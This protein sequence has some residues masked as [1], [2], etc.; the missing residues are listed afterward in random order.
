MES[1]MQNQAREG[2]RMLI[3]SEAER[4]ADLPYGSDMSNELLQ[5]LGSFATKSSFLGESLSRNLQV[6][7]AAKAF[8]LST[9]V[10]SLSDRLTAEPLLSPSMNEILLWILVKRAAKYGTYLASDIKNTIGSEKFHENLV[11]SLK[12]SRLP[13]LSSLDLPSS[14]TAHL[15][16]P[17]SHPA[18]SRTDYSSLLPPAELQQM[19]VSSST[20]FSS[21]I[22]APGS[23]YSTGS[24]DPTL[25]RVESVTV[26]FHSAVQARLQRLQDICQDSRSAY[27]S[28]FERIRTEIYLLQIGTADVRVLT[29]VSRLWSQQRF[30]V[31]PISPRHQAIGYL[32]PQ[33]R[34][35]DSNEILLQ[36]AAAMLNDR[37]MRTVEHQSTAKMMIGSLQMWGE[38]ENQER[39]A[40]TDLSSTSQ[41]NISS[42]GSSF[43]ETVSDGLFTADL[44]ESSVD[45]FVYGNPRIHVVMPRYVGS[46][47]LVVVG[48]TVSCWGPG[49][50]A[51]GKGLI[52]DPTKQIVT[53]ARIGESFGKTRPQTSAQA[54]KFARIRNQFSKYLDHKE[55]YDAW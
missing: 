50:Q 4:L 16:R 13:P 3:E 47:S 49:V 41:Q 12:N 11:N 14:Q 29:E 55:I 28:F 40:G 54:L 21:V 27:N 20:G 46:L 31:D 2:M 52:R 45:V 10:K 25:V 18:F 44:K 30:W 38:K 26:D 17:A 22:T 33:T 37:C 19:A 34:R 23:E 35:M 32:L 6:D 39:I 51:L 48:V 8:H 7:S 36:L 1:Q 43:P 5:F 42:S 15:F 9:V 24:V 53:H